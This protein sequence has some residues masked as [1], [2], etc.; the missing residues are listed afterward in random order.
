LQKK[1]GVFSG[2][3]LK[4]MELKGVDQESTTNYYNQRYQATKFTGSVY[5]LDFSQALCK[6]KFRLTCRDFT[7]F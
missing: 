6:N 7:G 4:E 2:S 1:R 5:A 3:E